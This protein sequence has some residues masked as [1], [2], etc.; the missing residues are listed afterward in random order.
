MNPASCFTATNP[1]TIP[2][3]G[4]GIFTFLF[5]VTMLN[6]MAPTAGHIQTM[7]GTSLAIS[8]LGGVGTGTTPPPPVP[9]PASLLLFGTVLSGT[10]WLGKRLRKA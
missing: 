5:D 2:V 7:Q 8:N 9:E 3:G 1:P 10:A 4:N 6:N